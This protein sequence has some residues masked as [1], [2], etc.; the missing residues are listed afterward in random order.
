MPTT[1][2]ANVTDPI[3]PSQAEQ[4]KSSTRP[5]RY[6]GPH[7]FKDTPEDRLI[8]YG[9]D[10]QSETLALRI[11]AARLLLLFGKSGLGK[12]SLLQAGVFK[13]LRD[14]QLFPILVRLAEPEMRTP[15]DEKEQIEGNLLD[16]IKDAT[17][18]AVSQIPDLDYVPGEGSSLWEFL[19]TT[20]F[21]Q[22]EL[23]MT[24]VLVFD[25]FE[26]I[27]T[28]RDPI[29]RT[30]FAQEVGAVISGTVPESLRRRGDI[31][32]RPPNAR[33]VLSFKEEFLGHL[34]EL[35]CDIPRLLQEYFRLV[36][37][38]EEQARVAIQ[39]PAALPSSQIASTPFEYDENALREIL[40]VV[41]GRSETIEPF[42]LQLICHR[43]E[44]AITTSGPQ[45]IP[46]MNFEEPRRVTLELLGGRAGIESI[47]EDFYTDE[48]EK[49]Q[50]SVRQ[51]RRAKELCETG[52]LS[53][54]GHRVP[55]TKDRIA[56][57]YGVEPDTL[58]KLVEARLLRTEPRH[59]TQLYELSHD[60]LAKSIYKIRRWR[61]PRRLY[62]PISV[63]I[64]AF[65]IILG[66]WISF[67]YMV[68]TEK[69]AAVIARNDAIT[70][71]G[72]LRIAKDHAEDLKREAD[73]AAN[74]AR[75][76]ADKALSAR[77]QA[78][79]L[80]GFL[81]GEEFLAKI[82]PIGRTQVFKDVHEKVG[83]YMNRTHES[84][85]ASHRNTGL[86]KRNEGDRLVAE[87]NLQA[88]LKAY[89]EA[90]SIFSA[91]LTG[92]SLRP[93]DWERELATTWVKLAKVFKD[94]GKL[95]EAAG[96]QQKALTARDNLL[97]AAGINDSER[98]RSEVAESHTELG[99]VLISRGNLAEALGHFNEAIQL[100]KNELAKTPREATWLR[101]MHE[102]LDGRGNIRLMQG[103]LFS[104]KDDFKRSKEI[105][106]DLIRDNPLDANDRARLA[107]A[108][109]RIANSMMQ[110]MEFDRALQDYERIHQSFEELTRWDQKNKSWQRDRA[111]TLA[112]V[113]SAHN[114]MRHS[115]R[116][117]YSYKTAINEFEYLTRRDPSN[118]SWRRDLAG[119]Y[120]DIGT[121]LIDNN[122]DTDG[123]LR[124]LKDSLEMIAAIV[125]KN[126]NDIECMDELRAGYVA[127]GIG[128][129]S[130]DPKRAIE[131][132]HE[133]REVIQ[134]SRFNEGSVQAMS[135][136]KIAE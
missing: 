81:I 113:A 79:D 18:I 60:A 36:G 65:A 90:E 25:Q 14:V 19:K 55:I 31:N 21:W 76:A 131:N 52:L 98:L 16:L 93:H 96:L 84:S 22:G 53:S 23:L 27:F 1:T 135:H 54:E 51:R 66:F 71:A 2:R 35:S 15:E 123:G 64:A 26:E 44:K 10:A 89:K 118:V 80:I 134:N 48:M 102:G 111:M 107:V 87:G 112:L 40:S 50:V 82:R 20:M 56:S 17:S 95:N 67:T 83:T 110:D 58:Q 130:V 74:E 46:A 69:L 120:R 109:S 116:T 119:L 78:E 38:T 4:E 37:L 136:M 108:I 127:L 61:I 72:E 77:T 122:L 101:L 43:A 24:P 117:I 34:V 29:F 42:Q 103:D 8:F 133:A 124:Y 94:Q 104:A 7:P 85:P 73:E 9:R 129:M 86:T 45:T 6:P 132:F 41:R 28:L 100:S 47:I 114:Q 126:P 125:L 128:L 99:L 70:A 39:E 121:A 13:K 62:L 11:Q 57:D 32:D 106:E 91:P 30:S 97:K 105:V 5:D 59:Y 3:L 68:T 75:A 49:L 63:G 88:A 115:E 33:I 92:R 12:T